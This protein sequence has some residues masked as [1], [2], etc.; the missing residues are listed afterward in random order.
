[1]PNWRYVLLG[2]LI[3]LLATGAIILICQPER[4]KPI[5]LHPA[6]TPSSTSPPR[7][8]GAAE[9]IQVQIHG[10]IVSPGVYSIEHTAR[11]GDLISA[12]GGLTSYADSDRINHASLLYDGD[13]F[14]IP[15]IDEPIPETAR[16]AFIDV[17]LGED[18]NLTY[19]L[20]LNL[21]SQV[22]L[23]TLPSIGPTKAKDI[24]TYRDEV[25]RIF[26]IDELLNIEGIGEIT[27]ET[28][29]DYLII[30]P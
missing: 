14:Y 26:E 3:G 12:A 24:I 2:I 28:L 17:Y 29:R 23:E 1:M 10:E 5:I 9:P 25:G 19:P 16:N 22:E 6:P 8:T 20:D 18:E 15:T 11:L 27:L 30:S 21:A 4:G 13:Y 7:P